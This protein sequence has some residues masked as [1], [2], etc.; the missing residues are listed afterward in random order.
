MIVGYAR[1]SASEQVAGL[2]AQERESRAAGAGK[3][4]AEQ[5]SPVARA[6]CIWLCTYPA[7]LT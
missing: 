6:F 5:T 7:F 4:F 3:L 2:E 1:T